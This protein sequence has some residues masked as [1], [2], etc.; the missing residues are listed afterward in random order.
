MIFLPVDDLRDHDI[1]LQLDRTSEAK[2]EKNWVPA[3]YFS[4]CLPDGTKIGSCDLRIGHSSR[5]YYGGNIGYGIDAAYRG[6]HTT[7]IMCSSPAI[8]PTRPLREPASWQAE[9]YWKPHA[10][11]RGM[12]WRWKENARSWYTGLI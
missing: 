7:W 3:Y 5:L 11:R 12:T 6:H 2:P 10:S 9:N 8:R 1:V 4:I